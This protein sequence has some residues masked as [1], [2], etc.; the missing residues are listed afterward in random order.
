MS[1]KCDCAILFGVHMYKCHT[2]SQPGYILCS[3]TIQCMWA[4]F[5]LNKFAETISSNHHLIVVARSLFFHGNCT[6]AYQFLRDWHQMAASY[7]HNTHKSC[8]N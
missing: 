1:A 4:T 5:M 8:V 3:D 2:H 7:H 6:T